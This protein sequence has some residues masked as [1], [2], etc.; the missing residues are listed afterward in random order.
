M[1]VDVAMQTV[2]MAVPPLLIVAMPTKWVAFLLGVL[3]VW[4]MMVVGAYYH[5][6]DP[7]YDSF[8]PVMSVFLGWLFGV[9]YCVPWL[10][11]TLAIR[12][13]IWQVNHKR[14]RQ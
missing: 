4:G 9:V 6:A 1:S 7:T 3:W 13:M 11:I 2:A 14:S 10:V 5:L 8:A 12:W